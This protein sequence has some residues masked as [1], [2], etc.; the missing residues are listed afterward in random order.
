MMYDIFRNA[1]SLKAPNKGWGNKPG[2][3]NIDID[4]A[5]DIE[6]IHNYRNDICH[7]SISEKP[8]GDFNDSALDLIGVSP[9][10]NIKA[11]ANE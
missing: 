11:C 10:T 4:I 5:D 3:D 2:T 7:S 8:T 1:L 9:H 6:R